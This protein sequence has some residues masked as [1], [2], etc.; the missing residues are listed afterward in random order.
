[1][2]SIKTNTLSKIS[3]SLEYMVNVCK[4]FS[5]TIE[6]SGRGFEVFRVTFF[7]TKILFQ[8]ICFQCFSKWITK[9]LKVLCEMVQYLSILIKLFWIKIINLSSF[10]QILKTEKYWKA[11]Y[12]S[13]WTLISLHLS[14]GFDLY[15]WLSL[16]VINEITVFCYSSLLFLTCISK[17]IF[18]IIVCAKYTCTTCLSTSI[19]GFFE[20]FLTA[21]IQ[22]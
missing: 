20:A 14:Y 21:V 5:L 6:C 7:S 2:L 13:R 1:M 22:R 19:Q 9:Y 17:F 3:Q 12:C 15:K 16:L 11:I 18:L 8:K 10:L 4:N